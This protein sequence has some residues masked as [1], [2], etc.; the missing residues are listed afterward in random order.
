MGVWVGGWMYG[1]TVI[2]MQI[3]V[4]IGLNWKWPTGTELGNIKLNNITTKPPENQP[5]KDNPARKEAVKIS[6]KRNEK[7]NMRILA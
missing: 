3:S 7:K 1:L 6:K 4:Q 2:I 5:V